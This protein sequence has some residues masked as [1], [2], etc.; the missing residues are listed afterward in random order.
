MLYNT[1]VHIKAHTIK[2]TRKAYIKMIFKIYSMRR[3][4]RISAQDHLDE[5]TK[6]F[7]KTYIDTPKESLYDTMEDIV[8]WA[9]DEY[10]YDED[11]I[12][13]NL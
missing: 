9:M 2:K 11:E 8:Y 7:G 4:I 12:I 5:F 1:I 3:Q 13:F 10:G 6:E